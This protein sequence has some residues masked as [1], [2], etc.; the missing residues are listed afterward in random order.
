MRRCHCRDRRS[1]RCS[2]KI[3]ELLRVAYYLGDIRANLIVIVLTFIVGPGNL[4]PLPNSHQTIEEESD[5]GTQ[6]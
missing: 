4:E 5:F 1:L 6:W 3:L 2:L